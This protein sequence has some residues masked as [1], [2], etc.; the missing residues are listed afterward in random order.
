MNLVSAQFGEGVHDL[1]KV[2]IANA[3]KQAGGSVSR[4]GLKLALAELSEGTGRFP[5]RLLRVAP[6]RYT[7]RRD[8]S[9][10]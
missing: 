4:S 7:L 9:D 6:G 10:A 5:P 8:E 3:I 1:A 2:E